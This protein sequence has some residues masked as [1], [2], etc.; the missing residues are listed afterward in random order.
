[1]NRVEAGPSY[2]DL[3]GKSPWAVVGE[4][5][6]A[7]PNIDTLYFYAADPYYKSKSGNF[8]PAAHT[9]ALAYGD[10]SRSRPWALT[11]T[12]VGKR[13]W[14]EMFGGLVFTKQIESVSNMPGAKELMDKYKED[15]ILCIA[16][17]VKLD[18]GSFKHIPMIDFSS[19]FEKDLSKTE[20]AL[21]AIGEK[22]G[23]IL[24]SGRAFHYY[25]TNLLSEDEWLKFVGRC[26]LLNT[27]DIKIADDRYFGHRLRDG[28]GGLRIAA[29][30]TKPSVPQ[31]VRIF[32]NQQDVEKVVSVEDDF[33]AQ[34]KEFDRRLR[35][36]KPLIEFFS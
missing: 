4:I 33:F 12:I 18:N 34:E 2:E 22:R 27:Q 25:G 16:S 11:S 20:E 9:P 26:L 28:Y 15:F 13:V 1:M 31:I 19:H 21:K 3:I 17:V 8:D 6:K 35:S 24:D 7:N 14:F 32:E 10:L 30:S 23:F 29:H 36:E 5:W